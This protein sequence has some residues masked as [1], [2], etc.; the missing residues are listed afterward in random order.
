MYY[1]I[2]YQLLSVLSVINGVHG[3]VMAFFSRDTSNVCSF[4]IVKKNYT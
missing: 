4:Q 2:Q 1:I 3:Y